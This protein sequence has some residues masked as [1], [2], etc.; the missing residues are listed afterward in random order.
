MGSEI[1]DNTIG[2]NMSCGTEGEKC[3]IEKTLESTSANLKA[4]ATSIHPAKT[5]PPNDSVKKRKRNFE[6]TDDV[7]S[8]SSK[9]ISFLAA[10]LGTALEKFGSQPVQSA[11]F[12]SPNMSSDVQAMLSSIAVALNRVSEEEQ[13]LCVMDMLAVVKKYIQKRSWDSRAETPPID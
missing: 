7:L 2:P 5:V 9:D 4:M 1:T 10:S 11:F 12:S 6:K 3:V 13:V 8:Q